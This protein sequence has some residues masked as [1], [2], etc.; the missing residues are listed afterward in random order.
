MKDFNRDQCYPTSGAC[1]PN[2]EKAFGRRRYITSKHG[3]T[4]ITREKGS[5]NWRGG[6]VESTRHKWT[7]DELNYA[8]KL[9]L[10]LDTDI[11][12]YS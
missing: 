1:D 10:L 8:G 3:E 6:V 2:I 5:G 4:P 9:V 7:K 11:P 12:L